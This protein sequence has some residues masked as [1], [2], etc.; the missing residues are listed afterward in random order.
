MIGKAVLI[1]EVLIKHLLSKATPWERVILRKKKSLG[2]IHI[3]V[4]LTRLFPWTPLDSY[5]FNMN[6]VL[7]KELSIRRNKFVLS[8]FLKR[9]LII[10]KITST[11]YILVNIRCLIDLFSRMTGYLLSDTGHESDNGRGKNR[12]RK[13]H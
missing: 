6:T 10:I 8:T 2:V 9:S 5:F 12:N 4:K 3:P 7:S 11:N 1:Q 13:A